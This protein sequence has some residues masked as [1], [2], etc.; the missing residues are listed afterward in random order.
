MTIIL[1][2]KLTAKYNDKVKCVKI[3]KKYSLKHNETRKLSGAIFF[4]RLHITVD[5]FVAGPVIFT[6]ANLRNVPQRKFRKVRLPYVVH[7]LSLTT[8]NIS[9]I[10]KLLNAY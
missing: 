1:V 3:T 8:I 5:R 9:N 10:R 6:L 2:I 4:A 7:I